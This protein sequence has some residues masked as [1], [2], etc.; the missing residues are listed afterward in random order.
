MG[1]TPLVPIAS[2]ALS[3]TGLFLLVQ[4]RRTLERWRAPHYPGYAAT[5]AA[6]WMAALGLCYMLVGLLVLIDHAPPA[7]EVSWALLGRI[8]ACALGGFGILSCLVNVALFRRF[9]ARPL[10]KGV[11]PDRGG[12][13]A[14][15]A[16][17]AVGGALVL[18]VTY[19]IW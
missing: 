5:A 16:A 17:M 1:V 15:A 13:G 14:V 9:T 3:L 7:Q 18:L 10:R 19:L 2:L 8:S 11:R 4:G 12:E 6:V